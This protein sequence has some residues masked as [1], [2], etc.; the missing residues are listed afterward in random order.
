MRK[1]FVFALVGLLAILLTACGGG[2]AASTQIPPTATDE[3]AQTTATEE[4]AAEPAATDETGTVAIAGAT[5]WECPEGFEGQTLA[6]YN[7]AT[8]IGDNTVRIF[9]EKCG[10]SITYEI[11]DSDESMIARLQQGNPGL[12][13]AFPT[14]Y[15]VAVMIRLGLV[16]PIDQEQIPNLANVDE[17]NLGLHFDPENEYAVPYL[18][19]TTGIAYNTNVYPD[20]ITSWEQ[21]FNAEGRVAWIDVPRSMFGGALLVL[22]HDPNTS[23]P[24]L[25][26]EAKNYLIEHSSNVIRI[27]GDDGDALLVQGEVDAVVEYGGDVYQQIVECQ[28]DDYGY[29]LPSEGGIRDATSIVLLAD[30]PNPALAQVFM[31]YLLDPQVGAH[32]ANTVAYPTPNRV[33]IEQGLILPELLESPA[34]NPSA[35]D[36]AKA[37]FILDLGDADVLYTDAWDEVKVNIGG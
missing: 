4:A 5:G 25:I 1:Y 11:Y 9:E 12:D 2:D 26:E 14:D 17:A 22:G 31:D 10:V 20:G 33:A 32:I 30:A 16:Q 13:V 18:N 21:L 19:G 28:C 37:W 36:M 34:V 24:A 8:Y 6:V 15:A 29:V 23:D 35:A 7:W 27:A 3:A